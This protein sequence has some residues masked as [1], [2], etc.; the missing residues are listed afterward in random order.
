MNIIDNT[1]YGALEEAETL[2]GHPEEVSNTNVDCQL[3]SD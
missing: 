1:Q 3:M 2:T